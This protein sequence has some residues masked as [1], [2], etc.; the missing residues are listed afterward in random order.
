MSHTSLVVRAVDVGYGHVKFTDGCDPH[1]KSIRTD[2]IPSQSPV[3]RTDTVDGPGV[4][5]QRD[6]FLVP[7]GD[8]LFEVGRDI[9]LALH[10]TQI[11]EDLSA[12]FC[13]SDGYAARLFGAINYMQLPDNVIDVL[14]LGLPITTYQK[15]HQDL[16]KRFV[17]PHRIN[18]RGT[19]VRIE[20]CQVYPQPLG[21]YMTYL[22]S[23]AATS[24]APHA[25]VIDPGYNTF[26]WFVCHGMAA[27]A[28]NS[29]AV[30]R[31]MGAVLR[32]IAED[33][34]KK[35]SGIDATPMDLVRAIDR[36]LTTGQPL[37]LYGQ[38]FDL[39][40]HL[41]AGAPIFEEAARALKNA[42]RSSAE[43]DVIILTGGGATLYAE[44][45]RNHFPRH[46]VV[47]LDDPAMANVRG[48]QIIGDRLAKSLGQAL[49]LQEGHA[50][51]A[52]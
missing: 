4:L 41:A 28:A 43:L 10:G 27:N 34:I 25:L 49:R 30:E 13:L 50:A 17:G 2:S 52:A 19:S 24:Q 16:A 47:T 37:R 38:E 35:I 1:D 40:P 11:T 20:R 8:R 3:A 23:G 26:D 15:H 7:V 42:V 39:A 36:S 48:F 12:D 46:P 32:A 22:V 31:G 51:A 6:T 45:I 9:R 29:G 5:A 18:S 21:S 44:T 33:I 14:V